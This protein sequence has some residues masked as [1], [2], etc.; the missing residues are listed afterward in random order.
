MGSYDPMVLTKLLRNYRSHEDILSITS[1]LFYSGELMACASPSIEDR[2]IG[3]ASGTLLPSKDHPVV[4]HGVSNQFT[5]S[6]QGTSSAPC[7][8]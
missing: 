2:F 4:F 5:N 8:R 1:K 6:L 3:D 7:Q